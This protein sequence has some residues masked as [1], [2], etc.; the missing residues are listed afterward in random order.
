MTNGQLSLVTNLSIQN[1]KEMKFCHVNRS[2]T[3]F[4]NDEDIL[5]SSRGIDPRV[6]TNDMSSNPISDL[7][8]EWNLL[9]I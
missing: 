3:Y 5:Y 4:W 1:R 7:L 2:L 8:I 9:I 6:Q